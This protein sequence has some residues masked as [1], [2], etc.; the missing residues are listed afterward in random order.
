MAVNRRA[1]DRLARRL[2]WFSVGLGAVQLLAPDMV[3][4]AIGVRPS[5]RRRALMRGVGVQ[6]LAV[7]AGLLTRRIP[8]A[9]LWSRVAGDIVHTGMLATAATDDDHDRRRLMGAIANVLGVTVVDLFAAVR[10]SSAS[11]AADRELRASATVTVRREPQEVYDFWRELTQLPTFLTHVRSV[12]QIGDGRTHWV[13]DS[14][15]GPLEYDAD[16][17]DDRPGQRLSWRSTPGS[18]LV[19]AGIVRF[20]PAPGDR[21]TEVTVELEFTPPAGKLGAAVAKL[22]GEHPQQQARDD[23]RRCKQLLEVG[24]I[25]RTEGTPDGLRSQRLIAQRPA[26]PVA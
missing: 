6:E 19:N 4:R 14:P 9:L 22:L 23:L 26:R 25:V 2:G 7:G 1:P 17:V 13:V 15:I 11:V 3:N 24:E 16:I 5:P 21:G 20:A 8:A 12:E 18:D 10:A